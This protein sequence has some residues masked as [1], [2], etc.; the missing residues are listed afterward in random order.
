MKLS[1]ISSLY[2]SQPFILKF[3][4]RILSVIKEL[5]AV[6][7]SFEIILVNDG[8]PDDSL[9][10][11]LELAASD[12]RVRVIDLSR[13][14]GHH[15]ALMTGIR[16]AQGELA[17]V[18]DCDLEEDPALLTTFW[19]VLSENPNCDAAFG[20]Q[21]RRKGE[22]WERISGA[23]FWK[24]LNF[25][26]EPKIAENQLIARL[27]T[28]RYYNSLLCFPESEIVF[29]GICN[30]V[31]FEQIAVEVRKQSK[32]TTSYSFLKKLK[33]ALGMI[34]SYTTKPLE[35]LLSVGIGV[36]ALSVV[37]FLWSLY[38]HL[39]AP[40][41]AS[42]WLLLGST[43]WLACGI[44]VLAQ[45]L[46][47]IYLARIYEQVKQRPFTIVRSDSADSVASFAPSEL[48]HT[49][50]ASEAPAVSSIR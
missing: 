50:S 15:K 2:R 41:N 7:E 47:G 29:S 3:Y 26:A 39:A 5:P 36:V 33:L 17:F 19:K 22:W 23:C 6:G 13:N 8:S 21:A 14:F 44:V 30:L 43:I 16:Y 4:Q 32:G 42:P 34:T 28:R 27:L 35:L 12:S 45:G 31:G 9:A 49:I 40:A 11:A 18:I 10:V 24:L 20:V 25:L 48:A 46:L 37:A 38:S 1:I